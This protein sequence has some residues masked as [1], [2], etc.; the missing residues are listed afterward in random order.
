MVGIN[1]L[2]VGLGVG[3]DYVTDRD[4]DVWIYQN[5]AWYGLILGLNLQLEKSNYG[6]IRS[7]RADRKMD[8]QN[9]FLY[10]PHHCHQKLWQAKYRMSILLFTSQGVYG[11][12]QCCFQGYG[13]DDNDGNGQQ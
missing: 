9:E 7:T 4:K 1:N 10:E 8:S 6:I 12:G 13:K 3:W 11:I 2:T 5:K